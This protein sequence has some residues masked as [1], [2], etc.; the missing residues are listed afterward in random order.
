MSKA[1]MDMYT[2]CLALEMAPHGVRVNSVNP[3]SVVSRIYCR[4]PKAFTDD[5]Y[6]KVNIATSCLSRSQVKF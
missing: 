4:G 1:A 6:A 3:G 2:E 5:E